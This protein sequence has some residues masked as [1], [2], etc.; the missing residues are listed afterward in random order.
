MRYPKNQIQPQQHRLDAAGT[1]KPGDRRT[2]TPKERSTDLSPR[3]RLEEL[4]CDPIEGMA[5]IAMDEKNAPELRARMYKELALLAYP[6]LKAVEI[7]PKHGSGDFTLEELLSS[8]R[9][10]SAA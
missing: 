10:V 5:R 8:Y 9:R 4:G 1:P 7:T 6:R 2:G 3:A